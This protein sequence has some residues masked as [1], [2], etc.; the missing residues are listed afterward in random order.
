MHAWTSL[1]NNSFLIPSLL[2]RHLRASLKKKI[3][4]T[5]KGHHLETVFFYDTDSILS[6]CYVIA[7]EANFLNGPLPSP[8]SLLLGCSLSPSS[9][10]PEKNEREE[11]KKKSNKKDKG[12]N[13]GEQQAWLSSKVLLSS[14]Y[15]IE[16]GKRIALSPCQITLQLV[17]TVQYA[18]WEMRGGEGEASG[19]ADVLPT[20]SEERPIRRQTKQNHTYPNALLVLT[21]LAL[22]CL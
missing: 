3:P 17:T 2:S 15:R 1:G 7:S 5:E 10:T 4:S 21:L 11:K 20:A 9:A 13:D 12:S 18:F 22:I 6:L 16:P 19:F 14:C 8:V